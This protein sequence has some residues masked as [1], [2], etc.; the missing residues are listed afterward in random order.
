MKKSV[1]SVLTIT[2]MLL[3][4]GLRAEEPVAEAAV[5]AEATAEAPQ[6]EVGEGTPV[7]QASSE[8]SKTAKK[9]MWQ[10]IGLAV[11]AVAIAVVALVLVSENSGHSHHGGH[12][13]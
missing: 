1:L 2:S 10:N 3:V 5:V 12:S 11:G 6:P 7:G 4:P 9:K 13:H 8:G